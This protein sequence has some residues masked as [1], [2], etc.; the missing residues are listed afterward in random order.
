MGGNASRGGRSTT[1]LVCGVA[2]AAKD[3][4]RGGRSTTELVCSGALAAK[5]D[6]SEDSPEE[7]SDERRC[8]PVHGRFWLL[9]SDASDDDGCETLSSEATRGSSRSLQYLCRT[10]T[11]DPKIDLSESSSRASKCLAKRKL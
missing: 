10:P 4:S 2:L 3:D 11:G 5:G 8:L 9:A 6:S 1:E 7:P